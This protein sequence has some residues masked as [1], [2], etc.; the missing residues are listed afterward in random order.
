MQGMDVE[1][2]RRRLEGLREGYVKAVIMFG[3]KARG[4]SKNGSDVDLLVLH[5]DCEV[6][7]PIR[8]RSLVYNLIREAIGGEYE[9]VTVIDMELGRF[10]APKEITSL[11]LNVYWDG[12]VVYDETMAVESFLRHIREKI[13]NSG[14]KRVG[15]G[16]AYY[17]TL[18]KPM[19]AI[20]IL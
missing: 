17:W 6:K 7:D 4:D 2:L 10:I 12:I 14:L 20:R 11:L 15:D 3:S 1:L 13:V 18:P 19:K 16:R 5:D 8:R 9:D